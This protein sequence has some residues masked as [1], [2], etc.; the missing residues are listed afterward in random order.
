MS[1]NK[2]YNIV[3]DEKQRNSPGNV[4]EIRLCNTFFVI[5]L[6]ARMPNQE[7]DGIDSRLASAVLYTS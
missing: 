4:I 3:F 2:Y 5:K 7:L 6:Y 1:A